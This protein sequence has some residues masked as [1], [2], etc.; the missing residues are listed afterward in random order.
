MP[1]AGVAYGRAR[2]MTLP[3]LGR[4]EQVIAEHEEI[5]AHL[6]A[7]DVDGAKKAMERHLGAVIPDVAELKGRYP[8]YFI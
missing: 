7:R 1:A 4:M 5:R 6:A 2:R 8:D 3:V